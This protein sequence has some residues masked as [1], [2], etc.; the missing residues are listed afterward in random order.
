MEMSPAL[1]TK[2]NEHVGMHVDGGYPA[3]CNSLV[4]SCNNMS[5]FTSEEKEWFSEN[6][7]HGTF[8]SPDEVKK[9][10]NL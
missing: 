5:E 9:A 3:S 2:L 4:M 6:L 10:I 1:R 8:N 7:P